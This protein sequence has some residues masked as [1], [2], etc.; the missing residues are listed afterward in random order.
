MIQSRLNAA[1][2]L[3]EAPPTCRVLIMDNFGTQ[4]RVTVGH[5]QALCASPRSKSRLRRRTPAARVGRSI[6]HL[7]VDGF[8]VILDCARMSTRFESASCGSVPDDIRKD[9]RGTIAKICK[10]PNYHSAFCLK[11]P[12]FSRYCCKFSQ[13]VI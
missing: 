8:A 13:Y 12:N 5:L 2:L 7:T 4:L 6:I 10:T 1:L 3:Y 11:Y 9:T